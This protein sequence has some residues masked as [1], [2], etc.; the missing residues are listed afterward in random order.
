[1]DENQRIQQE[2]NLRPWKTTPKACNPTQN[3]KH[4]AP[5]AFSAV[6]VSENDKKASA[7]LLKTLYKTKPFAHPRENQGFL[8]KIRD[9]SRKSGIPWKIRDSIKNHGFLGNIK[10][11]NGNIKILAPAQKAYKTQGKWRKIKGFDRKSLPDH[12]KASPNHEKL[13]SDHQKPSPKPGISSKT[14]EISPK[15]R[16]PDS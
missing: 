8:Q 15:T 5:N 16:F 10:T 9:S 2:I 6:L 7:D 1:M 13:S 14:E 12:G 3:D 4:I 11:L